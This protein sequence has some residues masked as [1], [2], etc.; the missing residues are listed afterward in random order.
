MVHV[1]NPKVKFDVQ[2]RFESVPKIRRTDPDILGTQLTAVVARD[3]MSSVVELRVRPSAAR[4]MYQMYLI[5]D[6]EYIVLG[7]ITTTPQL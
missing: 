3:N 5:V 2:A 7:F 1:D 4:F 6:K